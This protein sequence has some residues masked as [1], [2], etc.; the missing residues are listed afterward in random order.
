MASHFTGLMAAPFTPFHRDG[1]LNLARIE[2]LAGH[3]LESGVRGVFVCGTTGEG[4]SLSVE[5]RKS[6]ARRWIE[7]A[8]DRLDVFVHVSAHAL[9]EAQELAQ[10]AALQGARA[11]AVLAP[12][13]IKPRTAQELVRWCQPIAATAPGVPFYLYHIPSLTGSAVSIAE[14]LVH[15]TPTLPT[16]AGVKYTH[17]DIAEYS[18]CREME[19]NR[20][21]MLYGRDETLLAGLA[22][23][24]RGAVGSTY[25]LFAPLY[26]KLMEAFEANDLEAARRLQSRA[27][28]HIDTLLQFDFL[29]AAKAAMGLLG[30]DCGPVRLPLTFFPSERLGELEKALAACGFFEDSGLKVSNKE[31]ER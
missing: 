3:L 19:N 9:P 1:S 29:P 13:F 25:N 22:A 7:V 4:L 30:H 28:R 16:L 21:D 5:E 24:A 15:A 11:I 27:R 14:F 12:A 26:L 10:H 17:G 18:S 23:G 20:F 31:L 8:G 2:S 6:V